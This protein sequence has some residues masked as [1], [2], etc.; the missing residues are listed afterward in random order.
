MQRLVGHN[1][2]V[3]LTGELIDGWVQPN[4]GW[5]TVWV[6]G[7]RNEWAAIRAV[8]GDVRRVVRFEREGQHAKE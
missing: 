2:R 7:G 8:I 1:I 4:G 6:A 5:K 3:L